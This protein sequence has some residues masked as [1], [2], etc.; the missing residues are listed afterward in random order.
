M[1]LILPGRRLREHDRVDSARVAVLRDLLAATGWVERTSGFART[2]RRSTKDPGGL[3]LVGTPAHE[4][5]HLAAHLDDESR[6]A[7][8]AELR[9]TLVRHAVPAGAPAHLAVSLHRLEAARRGETVVVVA[10]DAAPQDLLQ[11]AWDARRT[12][13]TVL[14]LDTGDEELED[15]AH[16]SLTVDERSTHGLQEVGLDD[17]LTFDSV[18]HLVSLAA[19]EQ[20]GGRRGL[21]DRLAAALDVI[22]GPRPGEGADGW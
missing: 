22:S 3:L 21:R 8:V 1:R 2:M 12:G 17:V 16:E 14:A 11:R 20:P 19:G 18:Q 5:W 4:P 10:E 7:G 13:A 6:R 9:P 15:V